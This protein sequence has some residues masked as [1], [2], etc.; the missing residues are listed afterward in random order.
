MKG[1]DTNELIDG[2][3][4]SLL[5]EGYEFA[6]RYIA[7]EGE[8]GVD[9]DLTISEAEAI[10]N[11][12]LKL[13]LVQHV[14]SDTSWTPTPE[15]G[16]SYGKNAGRLAKEL[17]FPEGVN[18]FLDLE[19]VSMSVSSST[20]ID[21]CTNWYNEVDS[22]GFSPGIYVGANPGISQTELSNLPFTYYWKSASDVPTPDSGWDLI[23]TSITGSVN[24]LPVDIDETQETDTPVRWVG[25]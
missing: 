25:L 11:A 16:T 8:V 13:M 2:Y 22:A 7:R 21:Y 5:D 23:Q 6:I 1:I 14:E 12:G 19:S 18:I 3:T 24:G 4:Q 9:N 17:G 10:L 20:V 15:K